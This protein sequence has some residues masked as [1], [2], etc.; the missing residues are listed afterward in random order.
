MRVKVEPSV[1]S[2]SVC[3]PSSKSLAHRAIIC[4]TLAKG[5]SVVSNITF[6]KD[7]DATISC[8]EKLGANIEKKED[9]CIITGIDILSQKGN[10]SFDC[11]ESGSTIRFL[12]PMASQI[13]GEVTF[14]GHGRLLSRPM[15]VYQH[16][17]DQQHLSFQQNDDCIQVKGALTPGKY[18]L[19]GDISSQFISGLLFILPL[20]NKDST[21]SIEPPYES[22]SYVDLT[23][24][25]LKTFG[26]KIEQVDDLT[27]FI[28]GNQTYKSRNVTV[29]G[30]YSQ[31]AFFGVASVLNNEIECFN[32]NKESL[33]GD[34]AILPILEKAGASVQFKKGMILSKT[35]PKGQIIDVSNCPDLGPILCVLASFSK[36]G[37]KI[38]NASRL[39]M[40]ESD[41]IEAME[42]ELKKW[43]VDIHSTFDS[44]TIMGKESYKKDEIVSIYG[45][46]DHRIVM[47]MTIFGLCANSASVIEDAQAISKSYPGFFEDIQKL[48]GK[49]TIYD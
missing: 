18:V 10:R 46:N 40:K 5:K 47:A 32:M 44:I 9:S 23:V 12:I 6:S 29:E 48:K 27:Y 21:L 20:L 33:Q 3:I 43:D 42:Q 37:T 13:Q 19:K 22:K 45:H 35:Q 36:G 31:M 7:I 39:R 38:I 14:Y 24:S 28:K 34:K 30:D 41:R 4:A 16:L 8:M 15:E 2:G 26:V 17:F 1:L 49:V 11:G 25:M